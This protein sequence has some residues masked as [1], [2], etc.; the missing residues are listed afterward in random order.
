MKI[1]KHS[2]KFMNGVY[3]K[4]CA[5]VVGPTESE[6]PL[7]DYYDVK[8]EDS[9]CGESSWEKAESKLMKTAV[10]TVFKKTGLAEK[11]ISVAFAGDLV[12]QIV[13]SHYVFRDFDIP[14]FGVYGACSTS[15]ESLLLASIFV[16]SK[17]ADI[18]LAATSSHNSS[19]ERQFR[20]PTEYAGPKSETSQFTVTGSGV[21]LVSQEKSS[22]KVEAATAGII[23]DAAQKNPSD[24]GTA[25]APAA[26]NTIKQHFEDLGVD[27]SYYDLILTGDLAHCGSPI[28]IDI[29]KTEGLNIEK[30]HNDCGKLIYSSNQ[31]VFAGGSGCGCCAV[32]TYGYILNQLRE[33]KLKRV[34]VVATGALLS[35]LIMQ[36]KETIPCI[37]HAIALC[38]E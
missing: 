1:G 23:V 13:P 2:W 19:V 22:I 24:M 15:M 34:L 7:Q 28:L 14:F 27:E 33:K 16:D 26:A 6:G 31:P 30:K 17:N 10:E 8:F 21:A 3:I 18:A 5:T 25:M 12:N 29:L 11:D 37:A 4:D 32:V 9:Y 36:Q 35:P 38:A 20:N